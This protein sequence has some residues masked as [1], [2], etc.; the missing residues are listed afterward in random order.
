ML[1]WELSWRGLV[2][3]G[4]VPSAEVTALCLRCF[5]GSQKM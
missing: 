2:G 4:K 1:R 3:G 5:G